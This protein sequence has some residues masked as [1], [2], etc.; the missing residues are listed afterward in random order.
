MP[1][2]IPQLELLCIFDIINSNMQEGL[3]CIAC[4]D[5]WKAKGALQEA[6]PKYDGELE[7]PT[8]K[9]RSLSQGNQVEISPSG[10]YVNKNNIRSVHYVPPI[11]V[12]KPENCPA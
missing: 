12:D 9:C 5:R 10:I 8:F 11:Q 7:T 1:E 4:L 2:I 6:G 3:R